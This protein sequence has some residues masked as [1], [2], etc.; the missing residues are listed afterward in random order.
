MFLTQAAYG[1]RNASAVNAS[2]SQ[3]CHKPYTPTCSKPYYEGDKVG[4][5]V[6]ADEHRELPG[7]IT[8]VCVKGGAGPS[9]SP[10]PPAPT[11]PAPPPPTPPAPPSPP[12]PAVTCNPK[13]TPPEA[14]PGG[15]PCPD[16]GKP[17]CPCPKLDVE[18]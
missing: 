4:S 15:K 5:F 8:A 3:E 13:A 14:C 17:A 18:A 11:P 10:P 1:Y 6:C 9:P 2:S 16:C 12:A 7:A